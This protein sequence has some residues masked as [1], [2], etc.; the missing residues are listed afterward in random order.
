MPELWREVYEEEVMA[1]TGNSDVNITIR[2]VDQNSGQVIDEVKSQLESLG[3]AGSSGGKK[4]ADGLKEVRTAGASAGRTAAEGVG[5]IGTASAEA[6]AG[7]GALSGAMGP[8]IGV[9]TG[10]GIAMVAAFA[11]GQITKFID[12]IAHADDALKQYEKTLDDVREKSFVRPTDAETAR[13][14][15]QKVVNDRSR[16]EQDLQGI[17]D[18]NASSY[19]LLT[20]YTNVSQQKE[21][22]DRIAKLKGQQ[23]DLGKVV[24]DLNHKEYLERIQ[25]NHALDGTLTGEAK[26]EATKKRSLELSNENLRYQKQLEQYTHNPIDPNAFAGER[27]RAEELA[28]RNA[29]AQRILDARKENRSRSGRP[30]RDT[31]EADKLRQQRIEDQ[32][33]LEAERTRMAG[34][35]GQARLD[36]QRSYSLDQ[37]SRNR[38]LNPEQAQQQRAAIEEAYRRQS[39]QAQQQFND[40]LA[41]M[42][43]ARSARFMT[44]EE[45]IAASAQQTVDRITQ[46]WQQ[47]YGQLD[48][49]DQRRV[50]GQQALNA[51]IAK[52][53]AD[54]AQ[55]Q[56]D[57]RQR[58]ADRA[59]KAEQE[60]ISKRNREIESQQ[61]ELRDRLAWTLEGFFDDPLRALKREGQRIVAQTAANFIVGAAG[62]GI[63]SG[64]GLFRGTFGSGTGLGRLFGHSGSNG[65][66]QTTTLQ[67]ATATIS[68]G[69]A[70][71]TG[72]G[73]SSGLAG[74]TAGIS[75]ATS[76]L[77]SLFSSSSTSSLPGSAGTSSGSSI[78]QAYKDSQAAPGANVITDALAIPKMTQ[79]VSDLGK[80]LGL[81]SGSA[82]KIPGVGALSSAVNSKAGQAAL[83]LGGSALGVFSSVMGKG[84]IGGAFS[85]AFSGAR[86]GAQIGG[87]V[88]AAIG[89]I[90]GGIAGIFGFGARAKAAQ[91]DKT[92]VRPAMNNELQSYEA[93]STDYQTAYNDLDSLSLQAKQQTKQF[94]S[95]GEGY[96]NDTIR[97]EIQKAQDN[98]TRMEKAGRGQFGFT[99][100]QFHNGGIISDFGGLGTSSN[101]GYI[102]TR[103]GEIVLNQQAATNYGDVAMLMNSGRSRSDM[104]S[105]LGGNTS[106][107]QAL[108]AASDVNLHFHS[109][110]AKG[111]RNLLMAHRNDIRS[112]L[113]LSYQDNA[114]GF[115]GV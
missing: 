53:N 72:T 94:G 76:Q 1:R 112:A 95:G 51:E 20:P 17:K 10:M 52:I 101:E 92:Q 43:S 38:S 57:V 19:F 99:A 22:S 16:A 84:G 8:L 44:E 102:H 23:E 56:A 93:G 41:Q 29:E 91:Y 39:E 37:V 106:T 113:N 30:A 89:A 9:A 33:A 2:V 46:A 88:G 73:A 50:Q 11:V 81:G 70:I 62:P 83:G 115:D 25:I 13:S 40:R 45:K 77:S 86:L 6:S 64:G 78:I 74:P 27:Q 114:G 109:M 97:P 28:N 34:L 63:A 98:L 12:E 54:T 58:E 42:D 18:K 14:R 85:G 21:L 71:I 103:K 82:S 32:A 104:A 107:M 90:A 110:D 4:V 59:A 24:A 66:T 48:A 105:Y 15:F 75:G 5:A 35:T 47:L 3:N 80:Q 79:S 55:Q 108:P 111:A 49:N 96:Y 7:V 100:A 60:A 31:S 61:R 26:I 36:A 65:V 69:S 68:V 87:P 67:A